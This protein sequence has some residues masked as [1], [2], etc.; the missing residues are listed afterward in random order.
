[1]PKSKPSEPSHAQ[2]A[3]A[4]AARAAPSPATPTP[5]LVASLRAA[6]RACR[7]AEA[8]ELYGCVCDRVTQRH[9]PRADGALIVSWPLPGTRS[10]STATDDGI[11]L[12]PLGPV[13]EVAVD[14]SGVVTRC[15]VTNSDATPGSGE[16]R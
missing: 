6:A 12:V 8:D 5:A 1:M 11:R 3:R 14:A 13:F 7:S 15:G 2:P 9:F 16:P 10:G 4:P